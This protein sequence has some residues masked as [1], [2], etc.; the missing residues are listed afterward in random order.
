MHDFLTK[1]GRFRAK[2]GHGAKSRP[3]PPLKQ[4]HNT[5]ENPRAAHDPSVLSLTNKGRRPR[6]YEGPC[7]RARARARAKYKDKNSFKTHE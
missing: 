2:S 1:H 3:P 4:I 5:H 6:V 7:A